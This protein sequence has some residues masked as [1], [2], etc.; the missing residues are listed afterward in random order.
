MRG[1]IALL[2]VGSTYF[3]RG[4]VEALARRGGEWD[5]RLVDIDEHC[6]DVAVRLSRRI[7]EAYRAP[8]TLRGSTER[9]DVLP[10]ADV[11]VSTIGVGGRKAWERDVL[12][13]RRFGI[14]QTTGDT[15][16]AGGV[17]RS[18]R[19][20]P[21]MV[22]VARDVER[23]CPQALFVNFSNPMSTVCRAITKTT[24]VRTV[25]LCSG[26]RHFHR[27][28]SGVLGL[29]D[30]DV[31]CEAIGVN[32]FTWITG[33]R[34]EGKDVLPLVR[35]EL[36]R[37]GS[38]P[39]GPYT[40]ELFTTF[41]AFPC[42]GDGHI[43]EFVPGWQE[44]GA[45]YGKT[46]GVDAGESFE[47]YARHWD[48]VFARMEAQA[49]GRIPIDVRPGPSGQETFGDEDFFAEVLFSWLGAGA[50]WRTVNLPNEGQAAGLPRGAV[51]ESTTLIGRSEFRPLA[52]GE[53]PPG[54][55]AILQR[56][57]ATQEL[58][59]EAALAGDRELVLQALIA[60]LTVRTREEAGRLAD[61][62]LDAH[63]DHLPAFFDRA[64][65]AD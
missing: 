60:G 42:V 53:L 41:G 52:F 48:E 28:L 57:V 56:I 19:T 64:R 10:G 2:G 58:T 14:Y 51:L 18:L 32:H 8:V 40:W 35:R 43:C 23:L 38:R 6:L 15:F 36:E 9:R 65:P 39:G 11:V 30:S 3:T 20:I 31:F 50:V 59:V 33:L 5:L 44:K 55:A 54:I 47:Q 34:H 61:A 63:R 4:I 45:Y 27:E 62:L 29:A 24:R 25:G 49:D 7:V 12:V 46:F 17:S 1:A 21:T 13:P 16:G 22:E 26:V 37:R